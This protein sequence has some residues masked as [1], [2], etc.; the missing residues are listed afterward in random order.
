M[1][2]IFFFLLRVFLSQVMNTICLTCIVLLL[3][4]V[5]EIVKNGGRPET[6]PYADMMPHYK[7]L[8]KTCWDQVPG[9]RPTFK[10]VSH[11]TCNHSMMKIQKTVC[12]LKQT[13]M[14]SRWEL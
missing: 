6:P 7:E 1:K 14:M 12:Y 9:N 5:I 13:M 8:M 10:H 4:Q 11:Y 3:A 2:E